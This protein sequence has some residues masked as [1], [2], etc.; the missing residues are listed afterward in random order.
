[1]H[2]SVMIIPAIF[3]ALITFWL[4]FFINQAKKLKK[5]I[6]DMTAE[7][8]SGEGAAKKT[9]D[10]PADFA[11]WPSSARLEY[12]YNKEC[13]R[14]KGNV[15]QC[16]LAFLCADSGVS[17]SVGF[18]PADKIRKEY[19]DTLAIIGLLVYSEVFIISCSIAFLVC[20][21]L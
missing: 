1:M 17:F 4:L 21:C 18:S 16:K 9:A 20:F 6:I 8:E 11:E 12:L 13:L 5:Q 3:L 2:F 15:L 14:L 19:Q 10:L 7:A